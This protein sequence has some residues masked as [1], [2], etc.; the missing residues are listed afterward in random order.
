MAQS[1]CRRPLTA[2]AW[3]QFQANPNGICGRQWQWDR[4]FSRVLRFS[5][6]SIIPPVLYILLHAALLEIGEPGTALGSL[7]P[8]PNSGLLTVNIV[9]VIEFVQEAQNDF[10][11]HKY[12]VKFYCYALYLVISTECDQLWCTNKTKLASSS[13]SAH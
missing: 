12:Q 3:V 8:P 9:R 1:V 4:R 13:L 2:E 10:Y 7:P 6:V 11:E 5:P